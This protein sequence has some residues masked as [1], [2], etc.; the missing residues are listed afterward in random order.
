MYFFLLIIICHYW[1][2]NID[3]FDSIPN[4]SIW[5][6]WQS[7]KV[8][9]IDY[10]WH[11]YFQV[12]TNFISTTHTF[13]LNPDQIHRAIHLGV[14]QPHFLSLT[15]HRCSTGCAT[16]SAQFYCLCW[17]IH[18]SWCCVQKMDVIIGLTG[19]L[20]TKYNFKHTSRKKE[21]S[22]TMVPTT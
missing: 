3:Y 5:F 19:I 6:I 14:T 9:F 11:P 16:L 20:V 2:Q 12:Y 22:S 13:C 8:D 17:E 21:F 4:H 10:Q 15:E 7:E 1:V 18:E